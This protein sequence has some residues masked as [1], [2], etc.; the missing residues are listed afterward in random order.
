MLDKK[1]SKVAF[2]YA[3]RNAYLHDGRA[4]LGAV[5]GKVKA[6]FPEVNVKEI[7]P[8]V[9]EQVEKVNKLSEQE[10][11]KWYERFEQEG[12]EL[13]PKEK[14][15][16]L[17][18][19]EWASREQVVTRFAPNPNGP[20]HI[21]SARAAILSYKYAAR[22][23]GKFIL[24]YDDTDP[25]VK[26]PLP[27][28]DKLILEDLRWLG[29]K[30]DEIVYASDRLELYYKYMRKIIELGKAYVC[31][32]DP[33]RWRAL[34]VKKQACPCRDLSVKEQLSRFEKM[35]NHKFK[36]GQAVLRL[37]TALNHPDP[38]VRDWWVA[39]IVD[40]PTHPRV[41]DSIHLWP[42]YNFASAIDDHELG[43]TLIIRGQEHEQNKTKQEF[44]YKY[45]GWEY[46]HIFHIG[47]VMLEGS[48]L[49]TSKIRAGIES[50]IYI[51]WDDP[52][53][54]TIRALRR[55]GFEAKAIV[56]ILVSLGVKSSDTTI[57]FDQLAAANK[58][59][60]EGRVVKL[61]FFQ[62]PLELHVANAPA[63][64]VKLPGQ[65]LK[66]AAGNHVLIVEHEH[67]NGK[68]HGE[69]RLRELYN[70]RVLEVKERRAYAEFTC[71]EKGD[72]TCIIPWELPERLFEV[73]VMM[74]D[75]SIFTGLADIRLKACRQDT[76]VY[77]DRFGYARVDDVSKKG[78]LLY[79]THE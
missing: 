42:S 66:L 74:P 78:V 52:R 29:C 18:E 67:L 28:A 11:K 23:S 46:P 53:L 21:G 40:K 9:M 25:K 50:G 20:F 33:E 57:Q 2:K 36:E 77:L 54:G 71:I 16:E 44:L 26:K 6:L 62:N 32:C 48:V 43:V 15:A 64:E 31:T 58:R 73:S 10:L 14:Q 60:I 69:V 68:Q 59:L 47:R 8:L 1:I 38:S 76:H 13:K 34:I 65:T 72:V 55:R 7:V 35:L 19:L 5:I 49:S 41:S 75:A 79:Y 61:A 27:D 70:V 3:V 30:V 51:G 12:Y 39:R 4:D 17:P 22:Y 37:K 24:R 45:L 56:D 63:V